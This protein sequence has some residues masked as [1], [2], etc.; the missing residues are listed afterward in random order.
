MF[1]ALQKHARAGRQVA[2]PCCVWCSF[3]DLAEVEARGI[4]LSTLLGRPV[5]GTGVFVD[6]TAL[7]VPREWTFIRKDQRRVPVLLNISAMFDDSGNLRGYLGVARPKPASWRGPR[8][9][10]MP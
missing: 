4:E 5:Q 10:V 1:I 7:E 3:H 2:D 9:S 6:P 8:Q